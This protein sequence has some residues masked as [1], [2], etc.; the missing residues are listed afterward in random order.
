MGPLPH[1]VLMACLT[2]LRSL[3]YLTAALLAVLV[4]AQQLRAEAGAQPLELS[5]AALAMAGLG[6]LAG[7]G[8]AFLQ[9]RT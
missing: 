8:A 7:R 3:L 4:V 5:I 2:V 9:S 1:A 6:W